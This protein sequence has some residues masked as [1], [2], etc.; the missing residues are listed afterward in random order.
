MKLIKKYYIE[1]QDEDKENLICCA[2]GIDQDISADDFIEK[3]ESLLN[4]VTL[5][6]EDEF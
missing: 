4:G 1:L 5:M 3:I 6:M 2:R